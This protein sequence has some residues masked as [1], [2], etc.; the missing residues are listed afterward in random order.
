MTATVLLQV[1]GMTCTGCEERIG[2]VLGRLEG[3]RE[4]RADH[5]TGQ[6]RVTFDAARVASGPLAA[7]AGERI[8]RAGYRVTGPQ[9]SR[10]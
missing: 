4:A 5:R 2:K 6:V 3:V 9:E 10:S 7:L 8:E 1:E